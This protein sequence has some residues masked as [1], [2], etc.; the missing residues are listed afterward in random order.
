LDM[1]AD[2]RTG[3]RCFLVNETRNMRLQVD[4]LQEES[5]R[6]VGK[7]AT[8]PTFAQNHLLIE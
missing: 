2:D 4:R 3:G 6:R 8:R 7:L 5:C 1:Q